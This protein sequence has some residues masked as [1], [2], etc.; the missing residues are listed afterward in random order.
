MQ[1][2]KGIAVHKTFDQKLDFIIRTHEILRD[3][4]ETVVLRQIKEEMPDDPFKGMT[5]NHLQAALILWNIGPC[6]LKEFAAFTRQSRAAA[7]AL[8][9]RMVKVG[10]V[11]RETNPDNRR[12]VILKVSRTMEEHVHHIR[13][14]VVAWFHSI[15]SELGE[16]TFEKWYEAMTELD[17]ILAIKTTSAD[18]PY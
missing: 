7:S 8:I 6:S 9:D 12:E 5:T 11:D 4:L 18:V 3:Y 17:K 2:W 10:A 15:S 13:S 14:R 1:I 16:E